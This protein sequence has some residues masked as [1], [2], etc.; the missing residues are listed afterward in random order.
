MQSVKVLMRQLSV[1]IHLIACMTLWDD[2][3]LPIVPEKL[4]LYSFDPKS[5][6]K[7]SEQAPFQGNFGSPSALR[8]FWVTCYLWIL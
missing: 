5:W 4:T 7:D 3:G 1:V 8:P 6:T 2:K